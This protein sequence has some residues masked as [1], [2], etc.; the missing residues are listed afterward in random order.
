MIGKVGNKR[1]FY[2]DTEHVSNGVPGAGFY[3]PHD[4]V[5]KLKIDKTNYKFWI[6]KHDK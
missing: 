4:S 1:Y 5:E 3:S 6:T 2:E